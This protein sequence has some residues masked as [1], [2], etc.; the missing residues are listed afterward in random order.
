M[1]VER[2]AKTENGKTARW[3]NRAEIFATLT[4]HLG[5]LAWQGGS[6]REQ[7][8]SSFS[9]QRVLTCMDGSGEP[10]PSRRGLRPHRSGTYR[11]RRT[12]LSDALIH[13]ITWFTCIDLCARRTHCIVETRNRQDGTRQTAR[14][15]SCRFSFHLL[16]LLPVR[17]SNQQFDQWIMK[18]PRG[19]S[20]Y[21]T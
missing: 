11:V 1:T 9:F 8:M 12:N 17:P 20:M 10:F 19:G 16:L 13:E 14:P 21:C 2:R 18:E 4:W 15:M 5:H 6:R 3:R 7:R